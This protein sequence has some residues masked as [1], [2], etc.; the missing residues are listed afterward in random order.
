MD[1]Y[2]QGYTGFEKKLDRI[3]R[4]IF[5]MKRRQLL[6]DRSFDPKDCPRLLNRRQS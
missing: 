2:H 6:N 5:E 3:Q 4:Q 1:L